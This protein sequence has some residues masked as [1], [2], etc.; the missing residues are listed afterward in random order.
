MEQEE[1]VLSKAPHSFDLS[2]FKKASESMIAIN[3]SSYNHSYLKWDRPDKVRDYSEEELQSIIE[4]GSIESQRT[5]SHNYFAKNGFYKQVITHYA[6]LLKY[7]GI[8]IPSPAFGK[9][10]QDKTIAKR[11]YGAIDLVDSMKVDELGPRIAMKA[12]LDGTYYGLIQTLNK[13]TFCLM[14][15]P[16]A[17]CRTRFKDELGNSIVEFDVS[18]FNRVTT[19]DADRKAALKT[20]PKVISSYYQ[21]WNNN[22]RTATS[23]VFLPTD[24]GVAFNLFDARPYFLSM[25][26]ATIEYDKAVQ[27]QQAKEISEIKKLVIQK[28]PHLN[29]GSLLF[30]PE[31]VAEMHAGTVK[32]LK[33]SN[34]DTSVLTTYGD[35]DVPSLKTSDGVTN[36]TLK[37]MRE[38]VYANA[39]V[40]PEIFAASGSSS[41][42]TSL[43]FDVSLMMILGIKIG[44]F[45]TNLVNAMHS[46]GTIRFSYKVL[47]ITHHN[48][49][50]YMDNYFKLAGTGYSFLLPAIA[51][52]ISQR[53]L[54]HLKDLENDVLKLGE[55]LLPLTSAYTQSGAGAGKN[56]DEEETGRPEKEDLEKTEKTNKNQESKDKTGG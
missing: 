21:K 52:G 26:P 42:K 43:A 5:L 31:E 14:D 1:K 38:S 8:L 30:E 3:E 28:I 53:D 33:A 9:S 46:N 16:Q 7:S 17:Y 39:G 41:L 24:I 15:L 29:D 10:L 11:Y 56:N 48:D 49:S 55:K 50:D 47:P 25:I 44:N 12:L 6:T 2:I 32:M 34:P 13:T 22:G 23:W 35:V 20:Y 51:S 36:N 40:S 18:Y 27:T 4:S 19:N 54:S 45:I 37:L